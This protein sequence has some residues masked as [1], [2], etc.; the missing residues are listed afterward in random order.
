MRL[1]RAI[2]NVSSEE[3]KGCRS[4]SSLTSRSAGPIALHL[5]VPSSET[6]PFA[7]PGPRSLVMIGRAVCMYRK[8]AVKGR[9]GAFRSCTLFFLSFLSTSLL[10]GEIDRPASA[11]FLAASPR[12]LR[13]DSRLEVSLPRTVLVCFCRA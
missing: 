13:T 11:A 8:N 9:L 2:K 10:T 4:M 3:F 6:A 5:R 7:A 12:S 1:T